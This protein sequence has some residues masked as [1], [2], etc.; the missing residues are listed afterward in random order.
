MLSH[1]RHLNDPILSIY[2]LWRQMGATLKLTRTCPT[3]IALQEGWCAM[4][5]KSLFRH[6]AT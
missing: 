1:V 3:P 2:Y 5:L 4:G 6:E